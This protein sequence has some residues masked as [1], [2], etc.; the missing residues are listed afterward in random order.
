[1]TALSGCGKSIQIADTDA[2]ASASS[3]PV[4]SAPASSA[5]T[6]SGSE[7]PSNGT[8]G[9]ASLQVI[10]STAEQAGL[11]GDGGTVVG[12]AVQETPPQWVQLSAVTSAPISAPHL[13]NINQAV[14]YRFDDD[15]ASPSVSTCDGACA[16][17]WPPVTV[18]EGGSIY[19]AGVKRKDV[20]AIR[21][22]D[23]QIQITVGGWP[24][25]RFA[26]DSGPGDLNGEGVD[27]K[28]FAVGPTGGRAAG[29]Q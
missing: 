17:K 20:G 15:T 10:D 5:P 25:Y 26:G 6:G 23:G 29:G 21:R 14:L 7:S 4:S 12:A 3:A 1:M 13:I 9:N 19:M 24:L 22:R 18:R 11:S 27:G 8:S 28:W 2:P 16:R